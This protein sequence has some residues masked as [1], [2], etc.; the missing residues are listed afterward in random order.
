M[1]SSNYSDA[2]AM[3]F[4]VGGK[5]TQKS[6]SHVIN[7]LS[8]HQNLYLFI[9]FYSIFEGTWH[10]Y[11]QYRHN[12]ML[13]KF[14]YKFTQIPKSEIKYQLIL[15]ARIREQRINIK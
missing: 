4:S 9:S 10:A 1:S 6:K 7:K 14:R 13:Q 2:E 5:D 8:T 15:V 3:G 11:D 12:K